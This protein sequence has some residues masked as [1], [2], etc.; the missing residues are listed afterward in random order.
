MNRHVFARVLGVLGLVLLATTVVTVL[1]GSPAF[2]IGK[3][4]LGVIALSPNEDELRAEAEMM[5]RIANLSA[6]GADRSRRWPIQPEP[7]RSE[8]VPQS[9]GSYFERR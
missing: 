7:Q 5:A 4:L 8:R 6:V 1:F 9:S 2:V 3:S